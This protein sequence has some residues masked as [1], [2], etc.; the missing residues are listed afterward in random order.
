MYKTTKKKAN[1]NNSLFIIIPVLIIII[2]FGVIMFINYKNSYPVKLKKI[3]YTKEEINIIKDYS[4]EQIEKI[5][6]LEHDPNIIK[7]IEEKYFI[8]ENLEKYLDYKKEKND[9]SITDVVAVI[10]VGSNYEWYDQKQIKNS[11]LSKDELILVNK[12]NAL[13]KDYEPEDI[14][15]VSNWYSYAGNSARDIAYQSLIS[16]YNAAKEAG[17]N[18]IVNSSYRS[19]KDQE[20]T[21][22]TF[23][24]RYGKEYADNYAARPGHSEHQTGLAFDITPPGASMDNHDQFKEF[25][26]LKDNAHKYGFILR[27]PEGKTFITGYNYEPW[28]FRYVGKK[29]AEKIYS[30]NITFDEYYAYYLK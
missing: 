10:N 28:H 13:S 27:Y 9:M 24:Y 2:V 21:Y 7:F 30:E 12:F 6:T 11:D 15:N 23:L 18:I 8:M 26:W 3:G 19:Y 1:F 16:L 17:M 14:V 25:D 20:E 5:L 4:K 29:I 22:Q